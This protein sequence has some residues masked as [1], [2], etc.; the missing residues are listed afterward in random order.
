MEF[1]FTKLHGFDYY[2]SERLQNAI[3]IFLFRRRTVV[4]S[5]IPTVFYFL[6]IYVSLLLDRK[7]TVLVTPSENQSDSPKLL[8]I[9]I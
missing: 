6:P 4:L 5:E 1:G 2:H 3:S 9:F 8:L 7:V